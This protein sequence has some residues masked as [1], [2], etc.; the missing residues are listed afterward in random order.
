M[1]IQGLF[2]ELSADPEA[3]G[4]LPLIQAKNDQGVADL[5]NAQTFS[6]PVT[7]IITAR[8]I[9]SDYPGGPSAA[10]TVLDK[11]DAASASISAL[12]WAWKFISGEGLD[13]GHAATQGMLD[14]LATAGAGSV[15]TAQEASNLKSLGMANKSRSE[16]LFGKQTTANEVASVV[17][18]D[19]GNQLIG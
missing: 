1:I 7:R 3:L 16:I 12:K 13:I 18:D 15:L 14:F 10:A 8:G 5:L 11:L 17:R 19:S 6:V 9:L 2:E 4:Y